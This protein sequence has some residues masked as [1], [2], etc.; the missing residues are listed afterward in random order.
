MRRWL[1][2]C[3]A[4][5]MAGALGSA[6]NSM[7]GL[8]DLP[9]TECETAAH[10]AP[11]GECTQVSCTEAG[12]CVYEVAFAATCAGGLCDEGGVCVE[13]LPPQPS[14]PDLK[15]CAAGQQCDP[16]TKRCVTVECVSDDDCTGGDVCHD[17]ECVQCWLDDPPRKCAAGLIC[18]AIDGRCVECDTSANCNI[19]MLPGPQCWKFVC[20]DRTCVPTPAVGTPCKY[21]M[22]DGTCKEDA[23]CSPVP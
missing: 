10:C 3:V 20:A 19:Q 14:L 17:G 21:G 16:E 7:M 23:V 13:C 1:A 22:D 4:T 8:D 18:S 11:A 2:W 12:Q 9:G 6:C 5:C 15:P